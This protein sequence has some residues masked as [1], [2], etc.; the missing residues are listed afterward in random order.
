M[1]PGHQAATSAMA[2]VHSSPFHS[3][4]SGSALSVSTWAPVDLRISASCACR[5]RCG[6]RRAGPFLHSWA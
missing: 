4:S 6:L 1:L 5:A 3:K 2:S